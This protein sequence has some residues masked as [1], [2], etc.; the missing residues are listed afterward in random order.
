MGAAAGADAGVLLATRVLA[1]VIIPF[2]V[3]AAFIL[4]LRSGETARLFAWPINPQL[5]A[6]ALGSAY[7]GGIVFFSRVLAA[8]RWSAVALGFPAV[9]AFAGTLGVVTIV[10][11]DRFTHD[12]MAF[13][14]WTALYFTTPVLVLVAWLVNSRAA[15]RSPEDPATVPAPL[16]A[17]IA[18]VGAVLAVVGLW[19]LIFP[20]SA[21][22]VWAW[23]L[24]PLTARVIAA[25]FFLPSLVAI[26]IALDGRWTSMRIPLE[27]QGAAALLGLVSAI[28]RREDLQGPDY[29]VAGFFVGLASLVVA[30]TALYLTAWRRD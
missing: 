19:L 28:V 24:S 10:H 22:A 16:R 21:A 18:A 12:L 5:T 3:L 15:P 6:M 23:E 26:G 1:G 7:A 17:V 20:G 4:L 8:R 14:V 9:V 13:W 11:W 25:T 2:L 29:A 27:A 30:T